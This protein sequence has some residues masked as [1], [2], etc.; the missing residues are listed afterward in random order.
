S[1]STTPRRSSTPTLPRRSRARP[2]TPRPA[3][4]PPR[5]APARPARTSAGASR[6]AAYGLLR[7][8]LHHLHRRPARPDLAPVESDAPPAVPLGPHD[9]VVGVAPSPVVVLPPAGGGQ[10][11]TLDPAQAGGGHGAT[12]GANASRTSR[13]NAATSAASSRSVVASLCRSRSS[14]SADS[15]DGSVG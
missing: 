3:R 15:A 4:S 11:L 7:Q 1:R 5:T 2:G 12:S 14:S 10:V 13:R 8:P 6:P 9:T